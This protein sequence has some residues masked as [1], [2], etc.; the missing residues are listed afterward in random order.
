MKYW[1]SRALLFAI[2]VYCFYGGTLSCPDGVTDYGYNFADL[3]LGAILSIHASDG[4]RKCKPDMDYFHY[5]KTV[6]ALQFAVDDVNKRNDILPNITLGLVILD[7]CFSASLA[8]ARALQFMP[9]SNPNKKEYFTKFENSIDLKGC[10]YDVVGV[11][12][13]DT[14]KRSIITADVLTLFGIP[15]ISHTA[16]SD[17][18]SDKLR[19]PYFFRMVP[20]DRYQVKV[21]SSILQYFNW[22]HV[23][24]VHSEGSYGREGVKSLKSVLNALNRNFCIENTIE[25]NYNFKPEDFMNVLTS[26][27]QGGKVRV[28]IVFVEV[29]DTAP[30]VSAIRNSGYNEKFIWVGTDALSIYLSENKKNCEVLPG[31]FAIQPYTVEVKEFTK[32]QRK[33]S[34]PENMEKQVS[35]GLEIYNGTSDK[36]DMSNNIQIGMNVYD[37]DDDLV[38]TTFSESLLI[39][40]VY[41]F[42]YALDAVIRKKC[43]GYNK[44][45]LSSCV[46]TLSVFEELK[47]VK[48]KGSFGQIKFNDNGDVMGK[49]KISQCVEGKPRKIG[50]WDMDNELLVFEE[51]EWFRSG[52]KVPKSACAAP[53]SSELGL[54]YHFTKQ[55]CCWE[56]VE[57]KIN[58]IVVANNTRCEPCPEFHWPNI[59]LRTFC[60]PILPH[61]VGLSD[62][63]SVGL[64]TTSILGSLLCLWVALTLFRNKNEHIIKCTSLELSAV[65][66]V[67]TFVAYVLTMSFLSEPNTY[68]CFVNHIGF[69]L[70]FTML[71]A[72]L[73]VKTNRIYRIFRAG[74]RTTKKPRLTSQTSQ[75]FI[76]LVLIALQIITVIISTSIVPPEIKKQMP[77]R[78]E[79]FVELFCNLPLEGLISSLCYNL[80]LVIVCAFYA[81][82]TRKLPDNYNESRFIAFCVDTTLLI[83]VTFLPTYFTTSRADSKVTILALALLLNAY[84]TLLCLFIPRI[85]SLYNQKRKGR[86]QNPHNYQDFRIVKHVVRRKESRDRPSETQSRSIDLAVVVSV[87]SFSTICSDATQGSLENAVAD[88][89]KATEYDILPAELSLLNAHVQSAIKTHL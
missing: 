17:L 67:G 40:S 6:N 23:S 41:A 53:C 81:F 29:E 76:T 22:T 56:C 50:M 13:P 38:H 11:I 27:D 70:I 36:Q 33:P 3:N 28:I 39:D 30:L 84:V 7:D 83:W 44:E 59:K 80:I 78:T 88:G 60:D 18:L 2:A 71:Y 10:F 86:M 31:S 82:K 4:L 21:I 19:F 66:L 61:Y 63:I 12:G 49:Y 45:N 68:K 74:K 75:L 24:I 79:K 77:V 37:V 14:S 87:P 16:T 8:L 51:S 65:I 62:P 32:Y 48:F 64:G 58:E 25:I 43:Y 52:R 9:I 5:N 69:N 57:C 54:V 15:Q 89:K 20:P 55:T 34:S 47:R 35:P 42:A 1:N 85:Y 72:P 46:S 73:L 26:L